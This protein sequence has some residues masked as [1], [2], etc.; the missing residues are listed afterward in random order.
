MTEQ[1]PPGKKIVPFSNLTGLQLFQLIR[2][3]TFVFAGIGFAKMHLSQTS[4]GQ[5]ETFLMVSGMVTFFWVSGVI[6]TMLSA[7]P[8][9][10][11]HVQK[12]VF[13][14]TFIALSLFA[15]AAGALLFI[16]SDNL[17]SFLDKKNEGD[18][19]RL[20]VIYVILNSPS[21][22]IEYILFLNNRRYAILYYAGL[23]SM[24]TLAAALLPPAFNY[25]IQY[26]MYGL[27]AVAGVK[28]VALLFL[29]GRFS[30][31]RFSGEI[32]MNTVRLALP[33]MLSIFVSGSSEYI[34]GLIV[35]AKFDDVA[36]A[37]Y[38]YGAKELPIL[39][40][41]AN[42]FSTAMIPAIATNLNDGLD[43]IKRRSKKLMHLFFPLTMVLMLASHHLY[44][45]VFSE[46][47]IYSA[48]IFNIYLLLAI[49]RLVFPQT[50]LTGMQ[51]SRYLLISSVIEI[52]LNVTL[53]I[54]L[55]GKMGLPGIAFGTFIAFCFDKVFLTLVNY[56]KY[57]ISPRRYIPLSLLAIYSLATL[58]AFGA[59]YW[60]S[61][62]F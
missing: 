54:Y 2:Y 32:V 52:T 37:V 26:S 34:D 59:G 46:S 10:A 28:I 48:F 9:Q 11:P 49:P 44:Q 36:F 58:L 45:Y 43:E 15:I 23:S 18:F 57:G 7:Y 25:G 39:L 51:Q 12:Q 8:K 42:T 16:F 38:R 4:I 50:V 31:F 35:K 41:I 33:L 56:F 61:A 3:A 13:F 1:Q 55:A 62:R 40:I 20:A 29:L 22:L 19:I 24:F 17:L 6:N 60:I 53:S 21:F 5:F 30:T 14:N 47:F 27:I